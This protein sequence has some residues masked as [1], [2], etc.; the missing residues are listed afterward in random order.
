MEERLGTLGSG[1]RNLRTA[2]LKVRD[3]TAL[4]EDKVF[5]K[6]YLQE[7]FDADYSQTF[8]RAA[9]LTW[10][11]FDGDS[12][13]NW[14]YASPPALYRPCKGGEEYKVIEDLLPLSE[15][16]DPR[17]YSGWYK[18]DPKDL[19][20]RLLGISTVDFIHAVADDAET[21][22]GLRKHWSAYTEL[23]DDTPLPSYVSFERGV[24]T[25]QEYANI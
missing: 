3:G 22:F 5:I 13:W 7:A 14:S 12:S 21:K 8:V 15:K 9:R 10:L 4:E 17:F 1:L 2:R 24:Q 25:R 20:G 18:N 16:P 19:E 6:N 11:F 23:K